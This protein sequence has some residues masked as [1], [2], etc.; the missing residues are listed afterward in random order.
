MRLYKLVGVE[1]SRKNVWRAVS[2]EANPL[3]S[4][5]LAKCLL[6]VVLLLLLLAV[7]LLFVRRFYLL[8]EGGNFSEPI[9]GTHSAAG[10]IV[11]NGTLLAKFVNFQKRF[12][13]NY[14]SVEEKLKRFSIFVT[15]FRQLDSR[16]GGGPGGEGTEGGK[17]FGV[18]A[19]FDWSDEELKEVGESKK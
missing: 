13:R 6:L 9:D 19:F 15:N 12:S 11:G 2:V 14:S 10:D 4:S 18:T 3:N 17:V 8:G 16:G 1:R 5:L 7:S